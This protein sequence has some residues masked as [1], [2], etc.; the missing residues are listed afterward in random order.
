MPLFPQASALHD[1]NNSPPA[2]RRDL[3]AALAAVPP[4]MRRMLWITAALGVFAGLLEAVGVGAVVPLVIVMTEPEIATRYPAVARFIPHALLENRPALILTGAGLFALLFLFK[5]GLSLLI[6]YLQ[7]SLVGGLSGELASRLFADYLRR[8]YAFHLQRNAADINSRLVFG[9]YAAVHA[10]QGFSQLLVEGIAVVAIAALLLYVNAKAALITLAFVGLPAYVVYQA[11]R[12]RLRRIGADV[13][14]LNTQATE[15]TLHALGG[16]KELKVLG[17]E[18]AFHA[19]YAQAR[20]QLGRMEARHSLLQGTPR[21]ILELATVIAVLG[22]AGVMAMQG[23]VASIAPVLGLYAAAAFRVLPAANRLVIAMQTIR[24]SEAGLHKVVEDL[25]PA[26]PTRLPTPSTTPL[27]LRSEIC[28][29]DVSFSYASGQPPVLRNINLKIQAGECVGFAGTTG[30]GKSTLMDLLL[31]VLEP[32]AGRITVDGLDIRERVRDW[33]AG[34]GYV[35]QAIY[36]SDDSI[37]RNVAFGRE[38]AEISD[39]QV[40][41]SL[42]SAQLKEFVESLPNGLD[43]V[44]GERGVRLSGGQRQRVGI[45][46]ALYHQPDVLIL[47]EAT[48]ALDN[49]TEVEFMSAIDRLHGQ[50][51]ILIVAHR[52]STVEKCDRIAVMQRGEVVDIGP[53]TQLMARSP[54]FQAITGQG[55]NV[56]AH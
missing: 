20:A 22:L 13:H 5:T 1:M 10:L 12:K 3:Q 4:R 37:R 50:K 41:Q 8:P 54:N 19:T 55:K 30:A 2:F 43:T 39:K 33:Q 28:V 56:R 46:R 24:Y 7:S 36:L 23:L 32:T 21:L 31:G 51:T 29:E 9:V 11:L 42:E 52:L 34:I 48:S 45:A 15:S 26:I 6:S 18:A 38:D 17:R 40:W 14:Q 44:V 49:A 16:I 35:P 27:H 25:G 53:Y 47:D